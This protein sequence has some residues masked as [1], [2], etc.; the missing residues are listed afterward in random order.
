MKTRRYFF[1]DYGKALNNANVV[2]FITTNKNSAIRLYNEHIG[3][4]LP[5]CLI[6]AYYIGSMPFK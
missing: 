6:P 3:F 2:M 1:Y 4:T 5:T